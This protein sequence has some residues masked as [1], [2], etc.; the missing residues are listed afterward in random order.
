MISETDLIWWSALHDAYALTG[1]RAVCDLGQQEFFNGGSGHFDGAC[2]QFA[3]RCGM[4]G[5]DLTRCRSSAALWRALGRQLVSIDVVGSGDDFRCLDLNYDPAPVDLRAAFDFVTNVGTSEHI[6]NQLNVFRVMHDLTRPGAVM[7]HAVPTG[8][9]C[10]HGF[11]NYN[12]NL[13]TSLCKANGYD[14]LDSW[15]SVEQET[16]GLRPDIIEFLSGDHRMFRNVRAGAD[17]PIVVFGDLAPRFKAN[18]ASLYVF[19][20]RNSDAPFRVAVDVAEE[21]QTC[22]GDTGGVAERPRRITRFVSRFKRILRTSDAAMRP[23]SEP[24]SGVA[25]QFVPNR[26]APSPAG[27]TD[28]ALAPLADPDAQPPQAEL[29]RVR[30]AL[31]EYPLMLDE[32]T[33]NTAHPNYDH[34]LVRN[35]PGKIFNR[36]RPCENPAFVAL[37]HISQGDEI[38][39]HLWHSVLADALVEAT[40]IPHASQV[41]ER[42]NFI[43]RYVAEIS[44]KYRA[45]YVPGWVNLEDALFLYWLVRQ[46]KPRKI[47]QCGVCNGL[48]AAFMMLGLVKNGPDGTLSVIDMPPIFDP[49]DPAW[50]TEGR[51]YGVVIPEGKT[52]G[53]MVPNTYR[54]R[55]EVWNGDAKDLLPKM[56]NKLE[57][58]DIFYHDSDHSYNHMM[59]EFKEA[60]RK[61]NK[62]GLLIGDDVSWNSSLW[63]FA[64]E[65]GVPSYNFKGT[66]GV[67]F[68]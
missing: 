33:Y 27:N 29:A 9:Y 19:L 21:P 11:F 18:D 64:D 20:R 14:C 56:V 49:T 31:R 48:S 30:Q 1:I 4:P 66:V 41:F 17:H 60:K 35:F 51:V 47:V 6:L 3:E 61:L 28:Q 43:E 58:L 63:D 25:S 42:R 44:R 53:W 40:A 67:A 26:E 68:F 16:H 12:L 34:K 10:G 55:F 39:D 13:F 50:T 2:R 65:F 15:I 5:V 23:P 52:S 38:P 62:G 37:T 36:D 8:G 22:I 24:L 57:S 46:A 59:F 54:D 32:R 45:H 7:A